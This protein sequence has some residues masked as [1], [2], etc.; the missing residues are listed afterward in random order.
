MSSLSVHSV[1]FSGHS[2]EV[3]SQAGCA[4][5]SFERVTHLIQLIE[6]LSFMACIF[7]DKP[8][9]LLEPVLAK[10]DFISV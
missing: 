7:S 2:V 4:A 5:R 3:Q 1:R 8:F 10:Q 6:Q 9:D